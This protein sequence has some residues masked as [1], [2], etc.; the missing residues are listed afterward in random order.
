MEQQLKGGFVTPVVRVGDT[1]RRPPARQLRDSGAAAGVRA[2]H[3][4]VA[5]HRDL[6]EAAV[7]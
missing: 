7:A 4:W 1:V 5:A 6:L 2:A 3:A